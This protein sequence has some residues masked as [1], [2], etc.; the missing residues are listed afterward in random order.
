MNAIA[1]S[2]HTCAC[3]HVTSLARSAVTKRAQLYSKYAGLCN[4]TLIGDKSMLSQG[5]GVG[6][7]L[8][9]LARSSD[10]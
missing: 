6:A 2:M 9:L 5:S 4:A 3:M 7:Q 8:S 10:R 1:Q